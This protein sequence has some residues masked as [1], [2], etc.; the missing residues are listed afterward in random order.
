MIEVLAG[1]LDR[2]VQNVLLY[3][4]KKAIRLR[5]ILITV[6]N[7]RLQMFSC[8]DYIAVADHLDIESPA[9]GEIGKE[10]ALDIETAEK[11]GDWIKKDLK[12]V[13]KEKIKITFFNTYFKCRTED[14]EVEK[15]EYSEPAWDGWNVVLGLLDT[16][17]IQPKLILDFA[18]RP[19]RFAKL[20]RLKADKEA[21][22]MFRGIDINSHLVL[23]FKKGHTL[24][25]ASMPIDQSYIKEEFLWNQTEDP[26]EDTDLYPSSTNT[27]SAENSTD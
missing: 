19:D 7:V 27:E 9:L 13:H 4:N 24:V 5:E 25:G 16:Y 20:A 22:L 8:D 17:D 3:T 6:G 26:N 18:V 10:F 15:F 2:V 21:P 14:G 1:D 12:V 23:Q 11:F